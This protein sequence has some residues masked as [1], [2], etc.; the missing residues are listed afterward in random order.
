MFDTVQGRFVK[1]SSDNLLRDGFL[2]NET[3]D[4]GLQFLDD[5]FHFMP[6]C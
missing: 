6:E 4:I 3:E 5:E 1:R 2:F